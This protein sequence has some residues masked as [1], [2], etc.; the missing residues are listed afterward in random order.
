MEMDW[1]ISI[2][3][4]TASFLGSTI[5]PASSALCSLPKWCFPAS[6]WK[7][8]LI[9]HKHTQGLEWD[10]QNRDPNPEV[11]QATQ[12]KKSEWKTEGSPCPGSCWR[13]QP[14]GPGEGP[15]S[16]TEPSACA[17]PK[18]SFALQLFS[19]PCKLQAPRALIQHIQKCQT[20]C[21]EEALSQHR[22]V[23]Q[24][25]WLKRRF[26]ATPSA[27]HAAVSQGRLATKP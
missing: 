19:A 1:G 8:A 23:Q 15:G 12:D 24:P 27:P 22:S 17:T 3:H 14:G 21:L 6:S 20:R 26:P 13:E 5:S 2:A 9:G 25:D 4:R 11:H 18:L 7:R 10:S 16:P